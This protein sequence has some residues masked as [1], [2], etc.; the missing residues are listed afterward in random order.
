MGRT[1]IVLD[2]ELIAQAMA[3]AGVNTKK[4]AVEAA[5]RAYV[6]KPDYA[7]LL[8]LAGSGVIADGYDPKELFARVNHVAEPTVRSPGASTRRGGGGRKTPARR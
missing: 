2:D 7:G 6:R 3:R 4:A 5:L 1:N 8:A